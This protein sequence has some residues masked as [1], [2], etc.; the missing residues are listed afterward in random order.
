MEMPVFNKWNSE[1]I[2]VSDK[3]LEAY[4]NLHPRIVPKTGGRYEHKRFWK[5]KQHIVE[6]LLNKIMVPGHKGKKHWKTSRQ[7]SGKSH[8]AYNI[9]YKAFSII[10]AKT[11]KNPIEVLV[12]AI[13]NSAPREETTVIEMGGARI[14]RQIDT[15]PQRRVDMALRWFTQSSFQASSHSKTKVHEAL[16][17]ELIMASNNDPKSFSVQKK[18]ETERQAAA[19]R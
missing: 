19:S 14:P 8:K 5:S 4:I 3:G 1:G 6:R 15:S 17:N 12:R 13:E 2:R 18:I 16:A 10:E 7:A 9:V 11:K